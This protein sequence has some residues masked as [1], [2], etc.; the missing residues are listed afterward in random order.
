MFKIKRFFTNWEWSLVI[1]HLKTQQRSLNT[2]KYESFKKSCLTNLEDFASE[3]F[4]DVNFSVYTYVF[5]LFISSFLCP[6]DNEGEHVSG[7]FLGQNWSS[8][9]TGEH[10]LPH[11]D[12]C[13]NLKHR[14]YLLL[15]SFLAL[16]AK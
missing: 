15:L 3:L 13:T 2:L 12:K 6:C 14:Y 1:V 16:Y 11:T 10:S 4:I 7:F 9:V 8:V 5:T